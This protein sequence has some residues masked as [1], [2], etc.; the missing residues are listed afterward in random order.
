MSTSGSLLPVVLRGARPGELPV[1]R[2]PRPV[3]PSA[4]LVD[5]R[6]VTT[7]RSTRLLQPWHCA[8]ALRGGPKDRPARMQS[9]AW[10]RTATID[11]SQCRHCD[12]RACT[13]ARGQSD[14]EV[15]IHLDF[16]RSGAAFISANGARHFRR[17]PSA[18]PSA[19]SS[20]DAGGR[21]QSRDQGAQALQQEHRNSRESQAFRDTATADPTG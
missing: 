12:S 13:G 3:V 7:T 2:W 4:Q 17:A 5:H 14:R 1:A 6:A 8:S 11:V 18:A 10:R 9:C 15:V 20:R 21:S 16:G 19:P